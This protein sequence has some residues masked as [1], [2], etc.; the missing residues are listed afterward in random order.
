VLK[1]WYVYALIG[2][3]FGIFD[4][5]F[6]DWLAK[7]IGPNL[8]EN[9]II[10]TP[11]ILGLNYGIWLLPIIP[12]TIYESRLAKTIKNPIFAGM[13]TWSSAI[14]SYYVFYAILLSLG[15][16]PR[17]DHFNVFNQD[18]PEVRATYWRWFNSLILFQMFEWIP[19]AV[20]GGGLIG[21]VVWCITNKINNRNISSKV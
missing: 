18:F 6:L 5:F 4:W 16:L 10:V 11:I 2:L 12:V 3:I 17:L 15:R 21:A 14:L 7:D 20:V 19:I 13:L 1:R 8:G 9:S